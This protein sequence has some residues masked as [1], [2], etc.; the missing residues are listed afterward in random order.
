M[1]SDY[2]GYV[3]TKERGFVK[4]ISG[5]ERYNVL[6]ALDMV[7]KVMTKIAILKAAMIFH[8]RQ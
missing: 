5:R 8:P 4:T 2:L 7:T 6:G 3:L 1:G